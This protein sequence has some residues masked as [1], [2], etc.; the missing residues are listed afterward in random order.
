[1]RS[2]FVLTALG[3]AAVAAIVITAASTT[4]AQA[5][6]WCGY[7]T[8]DHAVI[9]CGYTTNVE[10]ESATGKG[11]TCFIDPDYALNARRHAAPIR[12]TVGRG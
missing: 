11:G 10:C 12:T 2:G 7:G 6:E 3:S 8:K 9:E 1:M 5:D 4:G